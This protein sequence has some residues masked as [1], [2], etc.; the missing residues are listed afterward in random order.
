MNNQY[1]ITKNRY[2]NWRTTITV[3]LLFVVPFFL[4]GCSLRSSNNN[5]TNS[6]QNT[7]KVWRQ[8]GDEKLFESIITAYETANP[9]VNIEYKTFDQGEEYEKAVANALAA[10]NGPDIWE[11]R[12]DELPRHQDKLVGL[13]MAAGQQEVFKKSFAPVI[14]EEMIANNRL[15]GLP[16][17]LDPLM[18][19]IN[20]DH[21]TQAKIEEVPKTWEKLLE[22][23]QKMTVQVNGLVLR[24]GFA[25]GTVSNVDRASQIIQLLMLQFKTQMV[26]PA[27]RN[28]TFH[29]YSIMSDLGT[30]Y[31][32]GKEA[33]RFYGSFAKP[34]S[35]Y[36][37]WDASQSY[38]TQAFVS[39]NL[40]MMIN[41]LSLF[42]QLKQLQPKLNYTVA[43]VPQFEV[44][45]VPFEDQPAEI[46]K[47]VYMAKYRSLVVSKPS[48]RLSGKQQETQANLAW[49]FISYVTSPSVAP[50]YAVQMSMLSPYRTFPTT[51]DETPVDNPIAVNLVSWYKG[52]SPQVVDQI[53]GAMGRAYTEEGGDLDTIVNQA[54]E[55]VTGVL[56]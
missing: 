17:A 49:G 53:M 8:K 44:K 40:S 5:Q 26:D 48:R 22:V 30:I 23:A 11:I 7:L 19:Y 12:N 37:S 51:G 39:G 18:L 16:M 55:A 28:A 4:T 31:Y 14:A 47:P 45:Q 20:A 3:T 24:P 27:H 54:A 15:Y 25:M 38:T 34:E 52:L 2:V 1:A 56:R 41:Y 33:L 46:S 21:F 35:G 42:P 9:T 43:T 32:P 13:P 10:G 36:L 50:N 29:L 6:A